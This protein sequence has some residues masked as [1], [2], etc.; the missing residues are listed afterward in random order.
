MN[1][2]ES[3]TIPTAEQVKSEQQS[4]LEAELAELIQEQESESTDET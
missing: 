2:N 4:Y 3:K 1:S